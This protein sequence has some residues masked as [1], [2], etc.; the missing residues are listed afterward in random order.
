MLCNG[1]CG[2]SSIPPAHHLHEQ[3]RLLVGH[4][5]NLSFVK[6]LLALLVEHLTYELGSTQDIIRGGSLTG[7][8]TG[9]VGW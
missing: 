5:E 7:M 3:L 1:A 4:S 8:V 9:M 2:T 6:S